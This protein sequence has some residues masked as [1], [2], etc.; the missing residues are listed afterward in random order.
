MRFWSSAG[1]VGEK[2]DG[3][4][5]YVPVDDDGR[6]CVTLDPVG[7][8]DDLLHLHAVATGTT[9]AGVVKA[10]PGRLWGAQLTNASKTDQVFLKFFDKATAPALGTDVP[11]MTIGAGIGSTQAYGGRGRA[12]AAGIAIAITRNVG[13]L[14]ATAVTNGDCVVDLDYT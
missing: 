10:A 13:D 9:N 11:V 12:F 1:I 4:W 6:L 5:A 14:D 2:G 8:R 3:Q 7:G